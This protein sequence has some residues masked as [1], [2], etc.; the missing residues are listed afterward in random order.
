M[1][2]LQR[3]LRGDREQG[4]ADLRA[5]GPAVRETDVWEEAVAVAVETMRR[6][7]VPSN[8]SHARASV[9]SMRRAGPRRRR[10]VP[11]S[12]LETRRHR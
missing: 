8:R 3:Y 4:S 6:V 10:S 2:H 9:A 5:L 7:R 1:S 11:N 12:D